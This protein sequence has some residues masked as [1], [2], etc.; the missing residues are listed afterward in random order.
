V[1]VTTLMRRLVGVMSLFVVGVRWDA[2]TL[3]LAVRPRWLKPRCGECGERAPGYD[4]KGLR[5]W[6]A[7]SYGRVRVFLEYAP[8]RVACGRCGGVRVEKV[9]WA[10][11]A[12]WFTRDFEERVA[13]HAQVMDKTAVTKLLGISWEAVGA[14]VSRV[15]ERTMDEDRLG[16][17]QRIGIDEFSYRK[18]HRYLTTVVDHDTR[19]VVWAAK[20][21][22]A[23]T[24]AEFFS[25][26]GPDGVARLKLATID[27]AGGYIKA[28]EERAPHVKIVFDRFHVQRLA[29]VAVDEV[30]R[31]I[32]REMK[33]TKAASAIK[34]MRFILLKN[35]WNLS[36]KE[37]RRLAELQHTNRRLYR[38]Y[39]LKEALAAALDYK[40]LSRASRALDDGLA[41]ATRSKLPAFVKLART[42]R[43]HRDRIL[44]YVTERITNGVVEGINNRLRTIARRSYGVHSAEPLIAMLHLC[45][46]GIELNPPVPARS[47]AMPPTQP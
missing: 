46:G 10:D 15:V 18:H 27:M 25:L 43:K 47:S 23:D 26:L 12:S 44:A 1:R 4:R 2:N 42:L 41:W 31:K 37:R 22:G 32:W 29:S 17:L 19:R 13:Y 39:L 3:I 30:R 6:R 11:H 34:G 35:P 33:G 9:P 40:Q 7:L 16:T 5:R 21:R 36:R 14:I 20:G 24:L 45:V 28:L 8:R 38:A